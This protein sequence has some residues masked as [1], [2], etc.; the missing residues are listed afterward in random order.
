VTLARATLWG[1]GVSSRAVAAGAAGAAWRLSCAVPAQSGRLA[2]HPRHGATW[3]VL[4]EPFSE[5]VDG[6]TAQQDR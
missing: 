6:S 2:A 3:F 5:S 1:R 4:I